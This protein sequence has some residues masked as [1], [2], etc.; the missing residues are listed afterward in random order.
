MNS[1]LACGY[2]SQSNEAVLRLRN[3]VPGLPIAVGLHPWFA[4]E[5]IDEIEKLI[6]GAL[7][8]AVGECGLDATADESMTPLVVQRKV[9][10]SQL[11]IAVQ[12]KLPVTVHSRRAVTAV[13]DI[14]RAYP[15]VRG[16]MHAFG[17]SYEQA[18][19]FVDRGWLIGLGGAVTRPNASRVHKL[20]RRL[21]LHAIALETDAPA[22]GLAGISVPNVRPAHLPRIAAALA[23]LRDIDVLELVDETDKSAVRMFGHKVL[24]WPTF[25]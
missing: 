11:E 7:P 25:D 10:E 6:A 12:M 15:A 23:E 4:T 13:F 21:P 5:G 3:Q 20:A 24:R 1:L 2:N 16:V 17:G 22:I 14:V 19:L 9:F 8:T 18:K